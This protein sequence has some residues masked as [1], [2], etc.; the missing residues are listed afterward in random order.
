MAA[1]IR[2]LTATHW[3]FRHND[4]DDDDDDDDSN[5]NNNSDRG[6]GCG[7]GCGCGV[8]VCVCVC[9]Q[10]PFPAGKSLQQNALPKSI[11]EYI[12]IYIYIYI[13]GALRGWEV[14]H[15]QGALPAYPGEC[16]NNENTINI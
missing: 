11:L 6:C 13:L 10:V 2:S 7:C 1:P 12:Y 14:S 3:F 16:H 9:V 8:C 5:N 15:R 4:D